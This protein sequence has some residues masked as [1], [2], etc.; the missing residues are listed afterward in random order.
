[1]RRDWYHDGDCGKSFSLYGV[2]RGLLISAVLGETPVT[3]QEAGVTARKCIEMFDLWTAV[4]DSRTTFGR[5]L[6][7]AHLREEYLFLNLA[8]LAA[9]VT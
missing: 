9:L 4:I 7:P 8:T 3:H 5:R 1:M 6:A 2:R